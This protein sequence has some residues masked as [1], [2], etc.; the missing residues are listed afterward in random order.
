MTN[1]ARFGQLSACEIDF[2][3][4]FISNPSAMKKLVIVDDEATLRESLVRFVSEHYA[5]ILEPA[6]QAGNVKDAVELLSRQ[7]TDLALLDINLPDGTAFDI[8]QQLGEKIDFGIIFITA[9]DRYAIQAIRY[10]AIDY[11]LKPW[12]RQDLDEAFTRALA[13]SGNHRL[14]H[15]GIEVLQANKEIYPGTG[16]QA[17]P[18]KIL[19]KTSDSIHLVNLND[20][21]RIESDG[22]Y[23]RF[24]FTD[25]KPLLISKTLKEYDELL[26][27]AGFLRAHQSHLVNTEHILSY[28]RHG[29]GSLIMQ[30]QAEIPVSHR[31]KDALNELLGKFPS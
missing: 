8:L 23:S 9:Y 13:S 7:E 3:C 11:I 16:D 26:S 2:F 28:N 20:I 17:R 4:I 24:V 10:S 1:E 29:G 15:A 25:K 31:K 18:R 14:M 5:G 12:S 6:G 21:V 30:D 27:E 22:N 19:L